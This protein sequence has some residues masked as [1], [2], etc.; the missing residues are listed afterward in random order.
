MTPTIDQ[1]PSQ[2][3]RGHRDDARAGAVAG[4][5]EAD[6]EEQAADDVRPDERVGDGRGARGRGRRA[7]RGGRSRQQAVTIAL[8]ITFRTR[9]S[10][11]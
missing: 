9:M 1:K 5:H 11:R 4:D 8:N 10:V 6:A 3:A 7:R 2:L